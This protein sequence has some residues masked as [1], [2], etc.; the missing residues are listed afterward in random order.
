MF[1]K[2]SHKVLCILMRRMASMAQITAFT[3]NGSQA[4]QK[5]SIIMADRFWKTLHRLHID[6][7]RALG[8]NEI[9]RSGGNDRLMAY[10]MSG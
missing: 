7:N 6:N 1:Q 5:I 8:Y 3:Q 4:S 9:A 10:T 2:P